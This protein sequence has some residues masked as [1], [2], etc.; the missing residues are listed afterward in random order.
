LELRFPF[1][2]LFM[3]LLFLGP[4]IGVFFL[5]YRRAVASGNERYVLL[6]SHL[7]VISTLPACWR[8]GSMVLDVIPHKFLS[9]LIDL[10]VA[11][12]LVAFLSY[13]L[14]AVAIA[15]AVIVLWA[16]QRFVF[17]PQR[18]FA[19]RMATG[20]CF[21]CDRLISVASEPLGRPPFCPLCGFAQFCRCAACTKHTYVPA[22]FC[23][24]C[25]APMPDR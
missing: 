13:L 10:L 7:L 18:V 6:S 19:R 23:H 22:T 5:A 20:A 15:I 2:V 11:F 4:L 25:A 3:E 1:V 16:L 9:Q 12:N 24:A 14:V 17:N 21:A 8:V